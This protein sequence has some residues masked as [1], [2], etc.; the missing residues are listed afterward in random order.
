[1]TRWGKVALILAWLPIA[2]LA[3]PAAD[4]RGVPLGASEAEFST[5][6][7]GFNC[8]GPLPG[9]EH[10]A[11]R[12]CVAGKTSEDLNFAGA[13]ASQLFATFLRDR[14][15]GLSVSLKARDFDRVAAA[16]REKFGKP[17]SVE[18]PV[19]Q[20]QGG[21]K[22]QNEVIVWRLGSTVVMAQKHARLLDES[23]VQYVDE[24]ALGESSARAKEQAKKNAKS[25]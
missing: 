21:L 24:S 12:V 23:G 3:Q 8:R 11:D 1:V 9:T 15:V 20:T 2:A 19:F 10:I 17:H 6:L 16:M 18:R 22:A 7:P 4:F 5:K 25:L 13:E 14:F